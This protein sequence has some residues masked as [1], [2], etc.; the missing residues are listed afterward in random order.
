[1]RNG[2]RA[3]DET[4]KANSKLKVSSKINLQNFR[5]AGVTGHSVTMRY[6]L[7][8]TVQKLTNPTSLCFIPE[9]LRKVASFIGCIERLSNFICYILLHSICFPI[10]FQASM[11]TTIHLTSVSEGFCL[12]DAIPH[13][14]QKGRLVHRSGIP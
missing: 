4:N 2:E 13:I 6:L 3:E 8:Y 12:N 14:S 7:W 5:C 1:M 11:C 10:I 9:Y